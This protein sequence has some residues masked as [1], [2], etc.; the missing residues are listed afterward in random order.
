[1]EETEDETEVMFSSVEIFE[2]TEVTIRK[3]I[4]VND[5]VEVAAKVT[6]VIRDYLLTIQTDTG[7]D[8]TEALK[9]S[10]ESSLKTTFETG[11]FKASEIAEF[12]LADL[13][14]T[15][16][17]ETVGGILIIYDIDVVLEAA[18]SVIV[19]YLGVE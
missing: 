12:T 2:A 4:G 14:T 5:V 13:L 16:K 3:L 11:A 7:L 10:V 9:S 6:K 8:V 15:V 17:E 1:M 19:E 18:K